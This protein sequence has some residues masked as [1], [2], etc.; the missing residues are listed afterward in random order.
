MKAVT[1]W[2]SLGCRDRRGVVLLLLL[3]GDLW[4]VDALM[5]VPV[6]V[7]VAED[8]VSSASSGQIIKF[9]A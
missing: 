8:C 1:A 9:T 3:E 6:P 4:M 2:V 5:G 7:P